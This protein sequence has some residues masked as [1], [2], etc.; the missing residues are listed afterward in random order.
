MDNKEIAQLL[1]MSVI[2]YRAPS[3]WGNT[4]YKCVEILMV[5]EDFE[6]LESILG[7]I[8]GRIGKQYEGN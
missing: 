2:T 6:H 7:S 4:D 3:Y 5:K 8:N 1:N